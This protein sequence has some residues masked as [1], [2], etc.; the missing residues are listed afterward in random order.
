MIDIQLVGV[1]DQQYKKW[2]ESL[3][4]VIQAYDRCNFCFKE[5]NDVDTILQLRIGNIPAIIVNGNIEL[6]QNGHIPDKKE[7]NQVIQK[8]LLKPMPLKNMLVPVDYSETSTNAFIYA[9]KMAET[10]KSQLKVVNVYHPVIEREAGNYPTEDLLLKAKQD[11]LEAHVDYVSKRTS[12]H[13]PSINT[14]VVLGSAATQL[15]RFSKDPYIDMIVMG[16]NGAGDLSHKLFGSVSKE[17]AMSSHCPVCLV[18]ENASFT[19]IKNILFASDFQSADFS[20]IQKISSLA[21]LFDSEV[22]LLHVSNDKERKK[23]SKELVLDRRFNE[24]LPDFNF[25]MHSVENK[26]VWKGIYDYTQQ[27]NVDLIVTLTKHRNFLNNL[28]HKS[29]T[30]SLIN[31]TDTPILVFHLGDD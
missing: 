6:E 29:V 28:F 2:K 12:S 17:V 24:V 21:M 23:A 9:S 22:H 8:Y 3:N 14:E 25:K 20:L 1:N 30:R 15:V 19:G 18:P 5:I 27:N 10:I 13:A 11:S 4:E 31:H 26:S 16:T 7:I